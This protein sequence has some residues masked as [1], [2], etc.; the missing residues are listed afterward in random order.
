MKIYPE[1]LSVNE[2]AYSKPSDDTGVMDE[3]DFTQLTSSN[4]QQTQKK[5]LHVSLVRFK[6]SSA[7]PILGGK[8]C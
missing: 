5:K 3:L 6:I 8:V 7:V 2:I 1:K 4:N